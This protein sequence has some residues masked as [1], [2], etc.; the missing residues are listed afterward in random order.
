MAEL[1]GSSSSRGGSD[2]CATAHGK[3]SVEQFYDV[4][5]R[6]EEQVETRIHSREEGAFSDMRVPRSMED[7]KTRAVSRRPFLDAVDVHHL[8][9]ICGNLMIAPHFTRATQR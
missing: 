8:D 1:R 9:G 5:F 3:G 7:S 6:D 2:P 4:L